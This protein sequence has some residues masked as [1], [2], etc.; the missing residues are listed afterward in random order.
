MPAREVTSREEATQT[1]TRL[2]FLSQVLE[3]GFEVDEG[4]FLSAFSH[5]TGLLPGVVEP[6]ADRPRHDKRGRE[7]AQELGRSERDN[8]VRFPPA[9]RGKPGP[10][11]F[12]TNVP[13][14]ATAEKLVPT[15]A[16][17]ETSNGGPISSM[18]MAKKGKKKKKKKASVVLHP[19]GEKG[20]L[21]VAVTEA[22]TTATA[23]AAVAKLKL[24]E[25]TANE[26]EETTTQVVAKV[27][28]KKARADKI[29]V[30]AVEAKFGVPA[31][32][33]PQKKLRKRKFTAAG[34]TGGLAGDSVVPAIVVTEA[35]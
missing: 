19:Q 16:V 12:S 10:A 6:S 18:S 3:C 35:E 33:A 11:P 15:P 32:L 4:G 34:L 30:T 28:M 26:E 21:A 27:T 13:G 20:E 31:P 8:E 22:A 23:T 1:L 17:Q 14:G 2:S 9:K 25:T 24:K 29:S 5:R 7:E